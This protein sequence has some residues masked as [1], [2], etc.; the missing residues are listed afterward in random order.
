MANPI[1]A[2]VTSF[3]V[4]TGAQ[5]SGNL[6]F[7]FAMT[8][9]FE[10]WIPVRI[11]YPAT[12]GISAGAEVSIYRS[13]DGGNSYETVPNYTLSSF[14]PKPTAASQTDRRDVQVYPGQ[15]LVSVQV[16]GGSA[17]GTWSVEFATTVW[18]I[19]AYS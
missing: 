8:A 14:F 17:A 19:T 11:L 15:Y 1:Q 5:Q 9:G 18:V 4:K 6:T 7:S 3:S 13:T 10:A 12:T 16:G 2:F